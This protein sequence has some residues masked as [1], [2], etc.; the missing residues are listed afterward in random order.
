MKTSK[1]IKTIVRL[2]TLYVIL[3]GCGESGRIQGDPN[4]T[5]K[6]SQNKGYGFELTIESKD[7]EAGSNYKKSAKALFRLQGK[8]NDLLLDQVIS[9]PKLFE[10]LKSSSQIQW[11]MAF[12]NPASVKLESIDP[13]CLVKIEYENSATFQNR[14]LPCTWSSI[15]KEDETWH[16][17]KIKTLGSFEADRGVRAIHFEITLYLED[18]ST[19]LLKFSVLNKPEKLSIARNWSVKYYEREFT[20]LHETLTHPDDKS[21]LI[22][23]VEIQNN[24]KHDIALSVSN[25]SRV[26]FLH[27]LRLPKVYQL[28][29]CGVREEALT[30]S[31]SFTGRAYFWPLKK[32]HSGLEAV[33][34]S[35]LAPGEKG[36]V[37]FYVR[38]FEIKN[39][40]EGSVKELEPKQILICKEKRRCLSR[41]SCKYCRR[42]SKVSGL[43]QR[44]APGWENTCQRLYKAKETPLM[45]KRNCEEDEI[46]WRT[47]YPGISRSE[48]QWFYFLERKTFWVGK[49]P[50]ERKVLLGATPYP[51]LRLQW[52]KGVGQEA[53]YS[54]A[55]QPR[56]A[57][58]S[59]D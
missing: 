49:E 34:R 5:V 43:C 53:G 20:Y 7:S 15:T 1:N 50:I 37:G 48:N 24:E 14:E 54:W 6:A 47:G 32:K 52:S 42:T 44:G 40:I 11:Q 55:L 57:H 16:I 3:V 22:Q 21:L 59:L 4:A 25:T 39:A 41:N 12:Q 13:T 36:L 18:L 17:G 33:Q 28:K 45:T 58:F 35:K 38:G 51:A 46:S 10:A 26:T 9:I 30:D 56:P 29:P 31:V 8:K 27:K 23:I 19:R 2:L